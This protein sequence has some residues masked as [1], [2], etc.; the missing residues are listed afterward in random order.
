MSH[1]YAAILFFELID[2]RIPVFESVFLLAAIVLLAMAVPGF[3]LHLMVLRRLRLDHSPT[4]ETL[5][6]PSVIYYGSIKN[7]LAM[8]R[9]LRR[10]E[11]EALGDPSLTS[12]CRIYR[13][14]TSV[15]SGMFA[16]MLVAFCLAIATTGHG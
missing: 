13:A 8:M 9:F 6:R 10:H 3:A 16:T 1:I 14:Y 7:G 2:A 12:V 15:Y 4:W 5:G 11:Y